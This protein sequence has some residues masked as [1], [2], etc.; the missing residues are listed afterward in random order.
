MYLFFLLHITI[1]LSVY[2]QRSHHHAYV[3]NVYCLLVWLF[4]TKFGEPGTT[5]IFFEE[6]GLMLTPSASVPSGK[7]EIRISPPSAFFYYLLLYRLSARMEVIRFDLK[8]NFGPF[9]FLFV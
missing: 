9:S 2:G 7:I 1:G 5:S 6:Y 8:P 3:F 4:Y